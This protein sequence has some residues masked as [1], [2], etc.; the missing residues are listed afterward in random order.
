[1]K[2]AY[3]KSVPKQLYIGGKWRD[4][5]GRRDPAGEDPAPRRTLVAIAEPHR[6]LMA[7]LGAADEIQKEWGSNP[8]ARKG[9]ILR[10]A[11]EMI[12]ERRRTGAPPDSRDGKTGRSRRNGDHYAAEFSAG[13]RA[14]GAD[15]RPTTPPLAE[16]AREDAHG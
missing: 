8:P 14:G 1:M 12:V 3:S 15:R 16:Q 9:E 5:S 4:A 11:G 10:R 13:S 2:P 7:A 6:R